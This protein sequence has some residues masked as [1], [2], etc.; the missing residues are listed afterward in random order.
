MSLTVNS[1]NGSIDLVF[2]ELVYVHRSEIA[3]IGHL[4]CVIG[5]ML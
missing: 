4:P 2:F 1:G 5:Y 3:R